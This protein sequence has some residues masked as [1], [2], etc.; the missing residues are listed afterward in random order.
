M[1]EM[2]AK[3]N[4]PPD[5]K[6]LRSTVMARY[7]FQFSFPRSNKLNAGFFRLQAQKGVRSG[8]RSL[9]RIQRGRSSLRR[10]HH[11]AIEDEKGR[12]GNEGSRGRKSEKASQ[13]EGEEKT[14]RTGRFG[15]AGSV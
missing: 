1:L 15:S 8:I 10:H 11:R 5:N 9:R 4:C 12:N 2:S 13:R 14:N 6:L 7:G 3:L